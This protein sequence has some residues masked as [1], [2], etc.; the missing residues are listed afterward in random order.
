VDLA[1]RTG[2]TRP[3]TQGRLRIY[4]GAAPGVGKTVAMLNEGHRRATRGTDVVVGYCETHRRSFTMSALDGLEVVPRRRLPYQDTVQEEMDLD[5][6]LARHPAVVLVDE[7]AHTNVPGS[8]HEKRYQDVLEL[9]DAGINVIT[10]LNIQHLESLNDA[11][12]A[13]TGVVQGETVPD[14]FVRAADQIDLVDMS[15]DALRRRMVHGHIYAADKVDAALANY[16]RPGN[17]SAL[18]ELA[19]LWLAEKVEAGLEQ[20]R[21]TH[22]VAGSWPVR[23]RVV[24]AL[25]GRPGG[26]ALLRRGARIASRL[27]GGELLAAHITRADGLAQ[28]PL[29]TVAKLQHVAQELGGEFHTIAGNDPAHALLDFARGVNATQILV[30]TTSVPRWRRGFAPSFVS[31]VIA[32]AGDIDVH[33]VNHTSAGDGFRRPKADPWRA[34][35]W[36]GLAAALALPVALTAVLQVSDSAPSI[37][38]TSPLFLLATI[39]V[40][41]IGG[42][43]PAIV[44]SVASALLLDRFF[45]PPL[46]D[47]SVADPQNALALAAFVVVGVLVAGIVDLNARRTAQAQTAQRESAALAELSHSLLGSTEQLP[48]L[49]SRAVDMFGVA[50]AALLRR[51]PFGPPT[52]VESVGE[53]DPAA[54]ADH[55]RVDDAHDLALQPPSLSAG[56]RRLLAAFAA[57][58][59]AIVQRQALVRSAASGRRAARDNAAKTA[60]LSALSRGLRSPLSRIK[61]AIGIL[62]TGDGPRPANFDDKLKSIIEHSADSLDSFIDNLLQLSRLESADVAVSRG[63]VDLSRELGEVAGQLGAGEGLRWTVEPSA[64]EVVVDVD[65]LG[66]ALRGIL[67]NALRRQTHAGPVAVTASRLGDCVEVRVADTGREVPDDDYERLLEPWEQS[68]EGPGSAGGDLRLALARG[69]VEATGGRVRAEPTPGGGLTVV[70]CLPTRLG[71]VLESDDEADDDEGAAASDTGA[72]A[73]SASSPWEPSDGGAGQV[74]GRAGRAAPAPSGP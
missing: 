2:Q 14:E 49:L 22:S 25:S 55:E 72:A 38:L 48:L 61:T 62:Q 59:G 23:E 63:L 39:V 30:G 66:R 65:L 40:A 29:G 37:G 6:I 36:V 43:V 27:A 7:L 51:S 60:L 46:G 58:A 41:L 31:Q 17:L 28:A 13:I 47:W 5:A 73:R 9:L 11:V 69:L 35:Q 1:S 71:Q 32:G 34:R 70:V 18:R 20:Y 45:V 54:E 74:S 12:T 21:T 3:M 56:Q 19:L 53:F 64:Q 42:L 44:A 57:H 67:T 24:V 33:V 8:R 4:L 15:P 50:G 52:V 10:T 26:E 68:G 16:F